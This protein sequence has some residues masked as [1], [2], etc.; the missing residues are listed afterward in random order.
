MGRSDGPGRKDQAPELDFQQLCALGE[1]PD[2]WDQLG[3]E[4][5][6]QLVMVK[7]IEY[8]VSQDAGRIPLLLALYRHAMEHLD[9]SERMELLLQF[10][11]M[12]EEKKGQGH[13][14]L[15][16][17]L[18][19]ENDP[20]IRS[21][22]AMKLS[23]LFDPEGGGDLAGP[24]FV[25]NCLLN[26]GVEPEEQGAALSGVL[27]LGDKRLLPLLQGAWSQLS[28]EARLGVTYSRSGYIWEGVVEFWLRCMETDCSESVLGAVVAAITRMPVISQEPYVYDIHRVL[29]CYQD[30]ETPIHLIRRSS[31]SEYLEEI[32]PR[33]EALEAQE[34]EP[35]LIPRIFEVWEDPERFRGLIG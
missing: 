28:E 1:N 32:R 5:L 33:L 35:K 23:L 8:G 3:S 4:E 34:S 24:E 12:T 14:G 19:A 20:G 17:Y 29:P 9:S 11:E 30:S 7:C 10:S 13:M 25:V 27:L 2:A 31:F 16:M 22:A 6:K 18:A 15:M 26:Q 21:T